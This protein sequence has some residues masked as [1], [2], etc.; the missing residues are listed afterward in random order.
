MHHQRKN[1]NKIKHIDHKSTNRNEAEE[2]ETRKKLFRNKN[3][4]DRF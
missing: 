3:S 1:K 4:T 2:E